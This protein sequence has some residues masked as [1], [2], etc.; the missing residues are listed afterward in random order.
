MKIFFYEQRCKNS[1][2]VDQNVR[3]TVT[4]TEYMK[5]RCIYAK[6]ELTTREERYLKHTLE[7]IDCTCG[8]L[9]TPNGMYEI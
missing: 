8:S 4:C 3:S 2:L 1:V 9:I 5:P 6:S 7:N